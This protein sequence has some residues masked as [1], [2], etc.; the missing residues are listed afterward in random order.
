M[1]VTSYT[2]ECGTKIVPGTKSK[3]YLVCACDIDT[4]PARKSTTAVG[5]SIT[6]DGDIVLKTGKAFAEIDIISE[7]GVI[8]H[9][10]VGSITSKNFTN[11]F[12]FKVQKDKASDEWFNN[13]QNACLVGIIVEKDG[14][15]RVFG[16]PDVPARIESAEGSTG[17]ENADEKS[18]IAQIMDK[19]GQVAPIY[20]GAIDLTV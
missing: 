6:L 15:M 5:D 1:D 8:K 12:D 16:Q 7:T 3:L 17:G 20:E 2:A 19:T 4:F 9:T 18:W 11:S 14:T 10:G 13:T